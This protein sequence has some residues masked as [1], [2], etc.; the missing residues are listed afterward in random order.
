MEKFRILKID[1]FV[2]LLFGAISTL[3]AGHFKITVIDTEYS[4]IGKDFYGIQYHSNTFNNTNALSKLEGLHLNA[5]RIWA[6]VA[7]FHP[8]AGVWQWEALDQKINEALAAGYEPI[9]CLYQSEDWFN[10]TPDDPWWNHPQAVEEW[11]QAAFHLAERY[12]EAVKPFIIFDEINML[13]PEQ[14]YYLTFQASARL[15]CQAAQQIKNADSTLLCGGPS[16]FGGWENGYWANEVLKEPNG[17]NLLDFVSSN[18]FISWDADDPDSLIMNRTIWYEEAP[19][20]IRQL[21]GEKTPSRLVLDAYNV[22]AL[23]KK[24]GEPWTDARNTN[25]FGGVYQALAM[26]HSARGGFSTILHWETLGG[27]GVLDWYPQF[28]A[29]PPYYAWKFITD[30]AG[31]TQNTEIIGCHTD[32]RPIEGISHHGGM[33]V[34]SYSL[35]PFA[36]R[37]PNGD[38]RI[39]LVNKFAATQHRATISVPQDMKYYTLYRFD[40]QRVETCFSPILSDAAQDSVNVDCPPMSV[41]VIRF[42][43]ENPVGIRKRTI[44]LPKQFLLKGNYPNPFNATTQIR[45]TLRRAGHTILEVFDNRGG[46]VATLLDGFEAVGMH[47]V[48]FHAHNLASGVYFFRLAQDKGSVAI[49]KMVLMK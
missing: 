45:F 31:L 39:V 36:L 34:A 32:E 26:L 11:Q 27:Y 48:T 1:L 17:E 29:L 23:W 46:K 40:Q 24:D 19:Q 16:S 8:Q 38:I 14:G 25:F 6:K 2:F 28:N 44:H 35:Q 47:C 33:N 37:L 20:K 3:Q 21:M 7:E 12:K 49:G 4:V 9:V 10:A 41:T 30:V 22:S 42:S 43:A 18:L 15:Y 5:V 13:H